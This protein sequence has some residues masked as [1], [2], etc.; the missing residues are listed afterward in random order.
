[1]HRTLEVACWLWLEQQP[2]LSNRILITA[3][4]ALVHSRAE[5]RA[6]V[7]FHSAHTCHNDPTINEAL[8]IVTGCLHPTTVDNLLIFAGIQPADLCHKGAT[9]SIAC[10]TMDPRHLLHSVITCPPSGN[11]WRLK[12]RH[13]FVHDPQRLS[14]SYDNII[15]STVLWADHP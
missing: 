11:A 3:T 2:C 5:H 15:R 1:M 9:L 4:L 6:S 8:R 7:W 14:S 10:C 12:S 13:L